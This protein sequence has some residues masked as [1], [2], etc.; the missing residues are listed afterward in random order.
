MRKGIVLHLVQVKIA[1]KD[2]N[3][4][5]GRKEKEMPGRK[6][7]RLGPRGG[8]VIEV[9]EVWVEAGALTKCWGGVGGSFTQP[10]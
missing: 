3:V 10:L 2:I 6:R 1:L 9:G 5:M 7:N 8:N 4:H